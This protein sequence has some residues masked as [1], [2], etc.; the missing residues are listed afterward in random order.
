MTQLWTAGNSSSRSVFVPILSLCSFTVLSFHHAHIFE[1]L[2][3]LPCYP[4]GCLPV[5]QKQCLLCC[6]ICSCTN[7]RFINETTMYLQIRSILAMYRKSNLCIPKKGVV[8]PQSQF[9][10]SCVC[11]RFIY[12]QDRSTYLA[13]EKQTDRSWKYINLSQIYECRNWETEQYNYVL[14]IT[15]LHSLITGNA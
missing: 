14:E 3:R 5:Y 10:H 11:E 2:F 13:T 15:R 9:L 4:H 1:C 6:L 12:S 8:R 7:M